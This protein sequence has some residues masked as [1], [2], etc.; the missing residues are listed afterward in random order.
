MKITFYLTLLLMLCACHHQTITPNPPE[1]P[2]PLPTDST[3]MDS[4]Y[5][6]NNQTWVLTNY[7]IGEFGP[8]LDRSDTLHFTSNTTYLFNQLASTYSFYPSMS[9]YNLTLNGS[10]LGNISGPLYEYNLLSGQVEGN[11]FNDITLGS[12]GV[13]YYLWM[14]RI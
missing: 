11:K 12:S 2:A 1:P 4:S 3:N 10:L 6:L 13:E 7:R 5:T 14:H 9:I 8:M